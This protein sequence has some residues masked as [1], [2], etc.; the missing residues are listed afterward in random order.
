MDFKY[1]EEFHRM[2]T[3]YYS[4]LQKLNDSGSVE[5]FSD[6]CCKMF[7]A[8]TSLCKINLPIKQSKQIDEN[9]IRRKFVISNNKQEKHEL[10]PQDV[11]QKKCLGCFQSILLLKTTKRQVNLY[12]VESLVNNEY[13]LLSG[14]IEF[15]FGPHVNEPK[16]QNFH[17]LSFP[18][19]ATMFLCM[20]EEDYE[21]LCSLFGV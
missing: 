18:D 1:S 9:C 17:N 2:F 19:G 16:E 8:L 11:L 13:R 5:L 12:F 3:Y 6:S 14:L 4:S 20:V 7:I 10:P 21:M 15:M